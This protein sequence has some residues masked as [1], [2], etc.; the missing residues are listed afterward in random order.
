MSSYYSSLKF[1]RF[2]GHLQALEHGDIAVPVHVRVKPT[3]HC[4]HN[5]WYCA[6]R[7]DE[8]SLGSQMEEQDSIPA[9]RL[10]ALAHE[11]VEIGVKAVTF[12]G[13]GE[14]LLYKALPE[15]I[16]VLAAGGVRV[17]ALTN[18][19]N[20]KGRIAEVLALHGT[21]IRFALHIWDGTSHVNSQGAK[22][23]DFDRRIN[24][25]RAFS[26][27]HQLCSWRL[28]YRRHRQLSAYRRSV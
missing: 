27:R 28:L 16:E 25:C 20:L 2:Q 11:F 7:T 3:N 22:P 9:Q 8:L 15:V 12:S 14:P 6:Y 23:H 17:A 21:W 5:C 26:A 18:G 10:L 4:N 19:S 1:L 13:G 24:N